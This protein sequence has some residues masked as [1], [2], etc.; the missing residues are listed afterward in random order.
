MVPGE[1]GDWRIP[2]GREV[3]PRSQ[4]FSCPESTRTRLERQISQGHP[5]AIWEGFLVISS[6]SALGIPEHVHPS[7]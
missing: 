6:H 1:G 4:P 3:V 2:V 7:I 5:L